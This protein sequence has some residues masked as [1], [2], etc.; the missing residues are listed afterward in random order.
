MNFRN[1]LIVLLIVFSEIKSNIYNFS[2]SA[3]IVIPLIGNA[4]PY[5]STI[6]VAGIPSNEIISKITLTIHDYSHTSANDVQ[7]LLSAPNGVNYFLMGA[8]GNTALNLTITFDDSAIDFLPSSGALSSGVF[9][10]AVHL[11]FKAFPT[12]SSNIVTIPLILTKPPVALV[13]PQNTLA[14]T[15][16]GIKPNGTWNLFVLD[17]G[18]GDSGSI[19]GGWTLQITTEILDTQFL[20]R[21]SAL[22]VAI[23]NKFGR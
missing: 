21:Q 14:N 11:G 7:V 10:P 17:A 20:G 9:K 1:L 8:V 23:R 18:S 12:M 13:A 15:F 19:S 16:N 22:F 3:P 5:P 4:D 2:N 6:N